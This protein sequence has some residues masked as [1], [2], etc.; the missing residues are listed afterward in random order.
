[1][2]ATRSESIFPD[3]AI[4]LCAVMGKHSVVHDQFTL[5]RNWPPN[6]TSTAT[7]QANKNAQ[8]SVNSWSSC[9]RRKHSLH[10]HGLIESAD[11]IDWRWRGVRRRDRSGRRE[12]RTPAGDREQTTPPGERARKTASTDG[13]RHRSG[14]LQLPACWG[15]Q[16]GMFGTEHAT[17][18]RF[19]NPMFYALRLPHKQ[20]HLL[21]LVAASP[22]IVFYH[23]SCIREAGA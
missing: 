9:D 12:R 18:N 11:R 1:M 20:A 16:V 2:R 13:V 17:V 6:R 15:I 5:Q 8:R 7:K 3:P 14:S 23:P 19:L 4:C 22:P 10:I 21:L